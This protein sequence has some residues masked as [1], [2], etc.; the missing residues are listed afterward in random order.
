MQRT[1][2]HPRSHTSYVR[3]SWSQGVVFHLLSTCPL[4]CLTNQHTFPFLPPC[5]LHIVYFLLQLPFLP[6]ALPHPCSTA[7]HS[8]L[9]CCVP[10]VVFWWGRSPAY[11]LSPLIGHTIRHTCHFNIEQLLLFLLWYLTLSAV[12]TR[13]SHERR[14][15]QQRHRVTWVKQVKMQCKFSNQTLLILYRHLVCSI[16]TVR[17]VRWIIRMFRSFMVAY[18]FTLF[19]AHSGSRRHT[20]FTCVFLSRYECVV[21][22]RVFCV[23]VCAFCP[24]SFT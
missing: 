19:V 16:H 4:T 23:D 11:L 17:L 12:F 21:C 5:F 8:F 6:L 20:L 22:V 14:F 9:S 1:K 2:L 3:P 24:Q 18:S 10:P 13:A 7:L 15:I